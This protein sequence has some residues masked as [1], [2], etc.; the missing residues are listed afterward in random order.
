[1]GLGYMIQ[2]AETGLKAAMIIAGRILET[3]NG[4]GTRL[5][6]LYTICYVQ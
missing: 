4:I 6:Y 2:A 3:G 1:M 5:V